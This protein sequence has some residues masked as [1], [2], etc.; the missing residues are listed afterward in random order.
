MYR[1]II[2]CLFVRCCFQLQLICGHLRDQ[3][4]SQLYR[5]DVQAHRIHGILR[6]I[7]TALGDMCEILHPSLTSRLA[8][9]FC[10]ALNE[11]VTHVLLDGGPVRWF[12]VGDVPILKQDMEAMASMFHADGD[13]LEQDKVEK[14]MSSSMETI[15]LMERDTASL[16]SMIR[17]TKRNSS[18]APVDSDKIVRILCHRKDHA[19]SKYLKKEYKFPKKL[20]N[21]LTAS[22][23]RNATPPKR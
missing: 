3:V 20:P 15:Q 14:F 18:H 13:G 11:A 19:A 22:I 1:Y 12:S 9:H 8:G 5:F 7:D 17:D 6:E 10:K 2:S 16:I 4:F 21:I 23:S